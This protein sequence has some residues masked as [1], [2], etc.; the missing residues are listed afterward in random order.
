MVT[1]YTH[2][3]CLVRLHSTTHATLGSDSSLE[4]A[5]GKHRHANAVRKPMPVFISLYL[6]GKIVT[7]L[8]KFP[9]RETSCYESCTEAVKLLRFWPDHLQYW[10]NGIPEAVSLEAACRIARMLQQSFAY[11]VLSE[12][13]AGVAEKGIIISN[14]WNSCHNYYWATG[15][16]VIVLTSRP[17]V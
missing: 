4:K 13:S 2:S 16:L 17:L 15:S 14:E 12:Q 10:S 5:M 7:C 11:W 6:R 9:L 8:K 1:L 3:D